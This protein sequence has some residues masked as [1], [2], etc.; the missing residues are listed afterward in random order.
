MQKI[1][2]KSSFEA[3]FDLQCSIIPKPR[4]PCSHT[5]KNNNETDEGEEDSGNQSQGTRLK[6]LQGKLCYWSRKKSTGKSMSCE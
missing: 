6:A 4:S 1:V 2:G 5:Q 3:E